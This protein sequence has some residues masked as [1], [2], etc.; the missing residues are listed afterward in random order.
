MSLLE[1]ILMT[2]ATGSSSGY[3]NLIFMGAIFFVMYFFMIRPQTK[4]AK[5][6]KKFIEEMKKGDS[7]VTVGGIHGKINKVN[8]TTV[9]LDVDTNT[10]LKVEKATISLEYTKAVQNLKEKQ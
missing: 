5:D 8:D 10:T 7:I 2:P 1:I 3:M 9:L 4:K 6:Q